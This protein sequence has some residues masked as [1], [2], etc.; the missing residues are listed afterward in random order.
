M[1]ILRMDHR[2]RRYGRLR[3]QIALQQD[4]RGNPVDRAFA[5]F[6]ADVCGDEQIFRRFRRHPFVPQDDRHGQPCFQFH[7]K[8]AHG[9][10]GKPFA[11]VQLERQS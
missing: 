2:I 10:N 1:L 7:H 5:F 6:S 8:R 9:L 4:S 3:R 11:T